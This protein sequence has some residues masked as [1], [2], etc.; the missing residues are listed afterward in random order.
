MS[1]MPLYTIISEYDIMGINEADYLVETKPIG[2]TNA[3]GGGYVETLVIN[4]KPQVRRLISTDPS[5][6]LD[7]R[8]QPGEEISFQ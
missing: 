5:L 3:I 4:G 6:Y 2:G 7:K 1:R 8:Y